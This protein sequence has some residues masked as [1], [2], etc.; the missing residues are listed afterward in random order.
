MKGTVLTKY[1]AA[2]EYFIKNGE[3]GL[4]VKI[5]RKIG[6]KYSYITDIMRGQRNGTESIRRDIVPILAKKNKLDLT[7]EDFLA[8]G[9]QLLDG[10]KFDEIRKNIE[11]SFDKSNLFKDTL[12]CKIAKGWTLLP[13][14]NKK[15]I[16][17]QVEKMLGGALASYVNDLSKFPHQS[18]ERGEF[19]LDIACRKNL[20]PCSLDVDSAE[21]LSSYVAGEITDEEWFEIADKKAKQLS[22]NY[23]AMRQKICD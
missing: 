3:R 20:V 10:K 1:Q 9:D 11:Y 17:M 23:E 8:I 16:V 18:K 4:R 19:I 15:Q 13:E 14:D 21:K 7:Y 6:K 2:L 12:F 5:G 22:E